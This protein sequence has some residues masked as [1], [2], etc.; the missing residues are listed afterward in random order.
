M[1]NAKDIAMLQEN[2]SILVF[3]DG[4]THK[5][6]LLCGVPDIYNFDFDAG[7][8]I[9]RGRDVEYDTFKDAP[10]GW[11]NYPDR[12]VYPWGTAWQKFIKKLNEIGKRIDEGERIPIGIDS[13][14]TLSSICMNY[15]QKQDARRQSDVRRI[16]DWG[17]QIQLLEMVMDQLTSWPVPLIVTA[18]A[19][20]NTNE[21]TQTTE[22]LPL[23][24][25]KLAGKVGIYFDEVYYSTVKGKGDEKKFTLQTE[26]SGLVKQVKTR[27][28]V[29]DG[30]EASWKEVAKQIMP[31]AA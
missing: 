6:H 1:A 24:T 11:E 7:M 19:Q 8:A 4:G 10:Q 23:L 13:L 12:G 29:T 30:T 31:V 14:T 26:S 27:Y 20:R 3:G 17:A 2:P 5:T 25:G 16:Q 15:V 21:V 28:G 18:H 22:I 9:A